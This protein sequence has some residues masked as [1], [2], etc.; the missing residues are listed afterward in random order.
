VKNFFKEKRK[1]AMVQNRKKAVLEFAALDEKVCA[2]IKPMRDNPLLVAERKRLSDFEIQL[3]EV[4]KKISLHYEGMPTP[5]SIHSV[6][7]DA[8]AILA[9][10]PLVELAGQSRDTE[11]QILIRQRDALLRVVSIQREKIIALES[12]LITDVCENELRPYAEKYVK[13]VIE[14]FEKLKTSLENQEKFFALLSFHGYTEGLRPAGWWTMPC[15]KIILFGGIG[16]L[17]SLAFF[18]EQRRKVWGLDK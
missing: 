5:D 7:K 4:E 6:E 1:M 16:N 13:A 12:K 18:I 2:K 8:A 11:K 9:G 14:S 10:T 3:K 17:S 15:E